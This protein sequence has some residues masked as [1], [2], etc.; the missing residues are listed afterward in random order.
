MADYSHVCTTLFFTLH[1]CHLAGNAST[2]TM[3]VESEAKQHNA[4][5][6]RRES[7]NA[8]QID[9]ISL[10]ELNSRFQTV[11]GEYKPRAILE[12]FKLGRGAPCSPRKLGALAPTLPNPVPCIS[13]ALQL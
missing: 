8:R 9:V 12:L 13:S 3:E 6:T 1:S 5:H 10:S 2:D 4:L 7:L 11:K